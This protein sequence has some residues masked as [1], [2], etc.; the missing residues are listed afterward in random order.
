METQNKL[1]LFV[2]CLDVFT[3]C[4][5]RPP[6]QSQLLGK[7]LKARIQQNKGRRKYNTN[8]GL[9]WNYQEEEGNYKL[10]SFSIFQ[11]KTRFPG[12]TS[13]LQW[14]W[15]KYEKWQVDLIHIIF[16]YIKCLNT[17]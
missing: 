11:N 16:K 12:A 2:I 5:H 14:M 4:F 1:G 15:S 3:P 13:L 17:A 7:K 6:S 10:N 9:Y 8:K